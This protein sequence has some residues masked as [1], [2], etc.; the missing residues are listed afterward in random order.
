[1]HVHSRILQIDHYD[2]ATQT[3][4]DFQMHRSNC[5][6]YELNHNLKVNHIQPLVWML[7]RCQTHHV[8]TKCLYFNFICKKLITL[9][10]Y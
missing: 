1:M 5:D 2:Q 10:G 3:F 6:T 4:K 8:K 7:V 9:M